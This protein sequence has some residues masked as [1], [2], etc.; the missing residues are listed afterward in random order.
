MR[1][2]LPKEKSVTFAAPA[3][4]WY[5][6]QFPISTIAKT[7]DYIVYMTYDLHGQWDVGNKW[8]TPG[9]EGGN[10][11][12]S[13]VNATETLQSLSMI[14]K[15]GVDPSKVIVGVTSY[16]RSFYMVEKGC[17]GPNCQFTGFQNNSQAAKGP[18]TDTAG[19]ISNAEIAEIIAKGANIKTWTENATDY[20]VY[21]DLEWVSY[22]SDLNKEG[23]KVLYHSYGFGGSTD[24]AIDLQLFKGDATYDNPGDIDVEPWKPCDKTY[25]NLDDIEKNKGSIPDHCMP[26]Y[27]LDALANEMEKVIKD[28]D[29]VMRTDYDK[30]FGYFAKAIKQKWDNDLY[31]FY[32]DYTDEYFNCVHAVPTDKDHVFRNESDVQKLSKFLAEKYGIDIEWTRGG[33][34]ELVF[35]TQFRDEYGKMYGALELKPDLCPFYRQTSSL[36][37]LAVFEEDPNDAVDGSA[38]PV[39]MIQ[40]AVKAMNDI[41]E[42]GKQIQKKEMENLIIT[43]LGQGVATVTGI[44]MIARIATVVAEAGGL[45]TGIYDIGTNKD[46]LALGIFSLLLGFVRVGGALRGKWADAGKMRRDMTPEQISGM[47]DIVKNGLGKVSGLT[48]RA[49]KI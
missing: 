29:A 38:V 34:L 25:G 32:H 36:I 15:A 1:T 35:C 4:Y 26:A 43:W 8:A 10:C 47:G 24:W 31:N 12:R 5:L 45:A 13:H 14:T 9:C 7:V 27:V 18:C 39:F 2:A 33:V 30:K 22:M 42:A 23:R 17:D 28:Y 44:A 46:N 41:Y 37:N 16:G 11:L 21:N 40:Q 19:Y 6:K 48:N 49:C 3:S 20:L